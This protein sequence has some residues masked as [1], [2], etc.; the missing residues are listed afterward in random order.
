[1]QRLFWKFFV[2]IWLAMAAS[3]AVLFAVSALFEAVPF[4]R[5]VERGQQ[6]FALDVAS[7]L[8]ARDGPDAAGAFISAAAGASAPVG[9]SVSRV[10]PP[11]G[12]TAEETDLSRYVES[13]GTCYP[14]FLTGV[15]ER[16]NEAGFM[17]G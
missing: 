7:Q 8:L 4:S 11:G 6:S 15:H 16:V 12:C 1:M 2:I 14:G 13:G 17:D 5:E 10:D 3:I 9:L